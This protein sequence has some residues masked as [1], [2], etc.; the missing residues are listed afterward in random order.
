MRL[1]VAWMGKTKA[2]Y[3]E[4]GT[5]EYLAR[6]RGF[7]RWATVAGEALTGR[8]PQAALL[9]RSQGARLWLF[10]PAGKAYD[11]PRFAQWIEQ[12][13]AAFPQEMLLAVGA[14]DGFA[15]E[16]HALAVGRL[17][18]SPLTL[19]HELARLVALEQVYR[20]LA[21]IHHHPYPH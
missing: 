12:Q 15:P 3:I 16:A 4:V 11:S 19:S 5:A 6:L 10:D 17:S 21:I 2:P 14:A 9:R 7:A 13:A 8:D 1:T 18:L 20:A